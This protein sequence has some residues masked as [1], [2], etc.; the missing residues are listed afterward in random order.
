MLH[1]IYVTVIN[2]G[3]QDKAVLISVIKKIRL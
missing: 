1:S 2:T 3:N